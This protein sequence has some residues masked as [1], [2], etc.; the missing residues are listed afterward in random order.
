MNLFPLYNSLRIASISSI[1]IF[2]LGI[3]TAYYIKKLPTKVKGVVDVVI[4][5]PLVLPP[6]V[7]GFFLIKLLG[8]N[9]NIG[10][11]CVNYLQIPL[12]MKWYSAVFATVIVS[13]PLMYRTCRGAFESYNENLTYVAQTLGKSNAWIFWRVLLP[14]CKKGIMAG[15]VLSFARSLGE[16]GATSMVSGY[17][18]GKTATISTTVYQFWRIGKDDLAYKWVVINVLISFLVLVTINMLEDN[19][20]KADNHA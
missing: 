17:T 2:F 3:V 5:L 13:F 8:P 7:V 4:T 18:P 19:D 20:R 11:F 14:N 12:I 9:S 1:I 16:Y 10:G 6:T 15:L